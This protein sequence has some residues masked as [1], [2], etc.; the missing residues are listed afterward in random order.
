TGGHIRRAKFLLRLEDPRLEQREQIVELD[1]IVLYRRGRE[2]QQKT[3]IEPIDELPA[4]A[5]SITQVMGFIHD[6]QVETACEQALRVLPPARQGNGCDDT[7]LVPEAI[8]I[9]A[10]RVLLGRSA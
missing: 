2:Q 6:D 10:Q 1:Q 9:V 7:L 8:R 4:L 3:L 5:G